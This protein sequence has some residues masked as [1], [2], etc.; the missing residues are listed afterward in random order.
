[1]ECFPLRLPQSQQVCG[2]RGTLSATHLSATN[3]GHQQGPRMWGMEP[4]VIVRGSGPS[5]S[6]QNNPTKQAVKLSG[7][8]HR[9][10][11]RLGIHHCDLEHGFK[12][13]YPY[14]RYLESDSVEHYTPTSHPYAAIRIS[15]KGKW[16]GR[17]R[18]PGRLPT[19]FS[20]PSLRP[21]E[22]ELDLSYV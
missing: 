9:V 15:R 4:S 22:E 21:Q 3:S 18:R 19:S 17:R 7:F 16:S 10:S 8:G 5:F 20:S 2:L 11:P 1:V 14:S 6:S 13:L 12:L